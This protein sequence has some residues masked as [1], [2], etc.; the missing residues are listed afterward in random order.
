M[1]GFH[2]SLLRI[3]LCNYF[4]L[5]KANVIKICGT[6]AIIFMLKFKGKLKR[7]KTKEIEGEG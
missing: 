5:H 4:I 3:P 2:F 1:K 6:L 7:E